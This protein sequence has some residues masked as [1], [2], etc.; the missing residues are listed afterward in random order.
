MWLCYKYSAPG[1]LHWGYHVHNPEERYDTNYHT[2]GVSYPA[3]NAHVVYPTDKGAWNSVRAHLQRAGAMD[4]ELFAILG[5]RDTEKAVALIEKV[6]RSFDDYDFSATDLD[7]VRHEL[8][9]IL[10]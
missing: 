5:K 3:G 4:Y 7:S 9:E 6:C 10:G 1:F 8:L 2:D